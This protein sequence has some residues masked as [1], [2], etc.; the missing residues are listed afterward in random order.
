ML[1]IDESLPEWGMDLAEEKGYLLYDRAPGSI[2]HGE[3]ICQIG[4]SVIGPKRAPAAPF[5]LKDLVSAPVF[6]IDLKSSTWPKVFEES[7]EAWQQ[8]H[9]SGKTV[10]PGFTIC[11]R[12]QL[13][14]ELQLGIQAIFHES[15]LVRE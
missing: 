2:L 12:R 10:S 15:V 6:R 11:I 8:L 5:L 7:F 1:K 4:R 13:K 14:P 9:R 3:G